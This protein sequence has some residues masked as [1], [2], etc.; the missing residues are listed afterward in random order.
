[1]DTKIKSIDEDPDRKSITTWNDYF[2]D[3]EYFFRWLYNN[4]KKIENE[5]KKNRKLHHHHQIEKHL[6]LPESRKRGLKD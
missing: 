4:K 5:Y 1:L 2:N 6:P 3:I